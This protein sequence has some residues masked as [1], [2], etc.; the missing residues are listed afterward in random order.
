MNSKLP[1]FILWFVF[2]FFFA[3]CGEEQP[4]DEGDAEGDANVDTEDTDSQDYYPIANGNIWN[5]EE[6]D[7]SGVKMVLHYEITG[8]ETIDFEH[9]VGEREVFVMENV[10]PEPG[11]SSEK[12]IQYIED[13]GERA[14]RHQHL[15]YD[16]TGD[17]TKQRDFVPGFL[18]FDRT[19]TQQGDE[20]T[21]TIE[22]YTDLKDGSQIQKAVIAYQFQL[23][24]LHEEVTVP[25]GTFDCLK[26]K[27][28]V[29]SSP[30]SSEAKEYYYADGIGKVKEVT[31]EGDMGD[32]TE[33][34]IDYQIAE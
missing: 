22:R 33:E 13:D 18:R 4:P 19:K 28:I 8:S 23:E 27:R 21:E 15:I 6:T 7:V 25:A 5:Y 9:E 2:C 30:G 11:A 24:S 34:L 32:K 10:F 14:V 29:A 16:D 17:L 26:I 20:W 1:S 3:A 12:R 31:I